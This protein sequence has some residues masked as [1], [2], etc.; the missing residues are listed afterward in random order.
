[1]PYTVIQSG[2]TLKFVDTAG[3]VSALTLPGGI[4]LSADVPP[5]FAL[6]GNY[7]VLVNSPTRPLTIDGTGTV[8]P[9]TPAAPT[10]APVVAA[11]AAGGLS[12]TYG[13]LRYT[14]VIKDAI[15]NVIAESDFSPASNSVT[16]AGK[17]LAVSA[18]GTSA[19]NITARRLY[20]PTNG[21]SVLYPWIDI[22]GNTIT[23]VSDDLADAGLSLV[24]A[25]ILG[26]PPRLLTIAEFRGRLFGIG[27]IDHDN[28]RYTEAGIPYA[29]PEDNILA[30]PSVGSDNYGVVATIPRR[31]A[32]GVGRRNTLVQI[33]GTGTEDSAG[34]PDFD[35]VILSKECGVESQESVCVFRDV[36]YFLWKDG[37]YSWGPSGIACVS[38]GRRDMYGQVTGLGQVRSWF[39]TNSY[40]NRDMF[41]Y[42][43][44]V[45]DVEREVY[46]LFLASAGS[47]TI[48]RW[49]EYNLSDGTWWGPH[50][51]D[52][53]NPVSAFTL[54]NVANRSLPMIGGS[55]AFYQEQST[56]TDGSSTAISL[57]VL[58]KRFSMGVPDSD[59]FFGEISILGRPQTSGKLSIISRTGTL[60]ATRTLT[61]YYDQ[62]LA[63]QRLGRLGVGK[64]SQIEFTQADAGVDVE[65]MGY[66]IDPVTLIGRR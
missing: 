43:F 30:I 41:P 58:G 38:N 11:G 47:N 8:R 5:R 52:L 48:D 16:I 39:T 64:H 19:E 45:I 13:G 21:G 3:A 65:I 27:D 33:T 36:A 60:D 29:W 44:A 66:H 2:T 23:T 57:D 50:K 24:P 20:R 32:L 14:F 46:K 9:L 28:L 15:G 34:I 12:G 26:T 1:M 51:T 17:L 10:T 56:R 53:F 22:D 31:D 61:Q 35:V 54:V 6:Y 63:R 40:F 37:V 7:V 59:K 62:T 49:I 18:V 4:S 25:P 55:N 42:A